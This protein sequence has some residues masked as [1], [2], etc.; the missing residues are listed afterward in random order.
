MDG[1]YTF[2][3]HFILKEKDTPS[4]DYIVRA[5]C[6][7][8]NSRSVSAEID[9]EPGSYEVI[10]KIVAKQFSDPDEGEVVAQVANKKPQKL[11]QIGMNYDIAHAKA[12]VEPLTSEEK[13][14]EE[15]EQRKEK[16]K[17][18]LAS[19]RQHR[20]EFEAWQKEKRE[21]EAFEAWQKEKNQDSV[22]AKV[23]SS[24][25]PPVENTI[26]KHADAAVHQP[27]SSSTK[28]NPQPA[29]VEQKPKKAT[30]DKEEEEKQ[31][32]WNAVCVFGLRVYS[33]DKEVTIRLAKPKDA[34]AAS[35]DTGGAT[36]AGATM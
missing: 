1:R 15:K 25:I 31:T 18:D 5:R 10:P 22:S 6:P 4:A 19:Y 32:P 12:L 36:Q 9:L 24:D 2:D 23:A 29:D 17:A 34:E 7:R 3:L 26:S 35:L 21:R 30:E 11:R 13:A 16:E 28:V 8:L 20:A 14:V 33:Q 27:T